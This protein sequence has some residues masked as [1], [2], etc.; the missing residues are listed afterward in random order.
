MASRANH[1]STFLWCQ[2]PPSRIPSDANTTAVLTN[3][4]LEE[5]CKGLDLLDK[6]VP[7]PMNVLL[8]RG[9]VQ[10]IGEMLSYSG[11]DHS[12][13]GGTSWMANNELEMMCDF[14]MRDGR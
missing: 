9:K 13:A 10:L 12:L 3:R 11:L 5:A 1:Q 2:Y 4:D 8:G 14:L 6:L 7:P